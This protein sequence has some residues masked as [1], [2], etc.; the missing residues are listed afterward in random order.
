MVS[1]VHVATSETFETDGS[2][3]GRGC[4]MFRLCSDYVPTGDSRRDFIGAEGRCCIEEN[5]KAGGK[6]KRTLPLGNV[7]FN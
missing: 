5:L 1:K 3:E 6:R 7:L 4:M 2:G